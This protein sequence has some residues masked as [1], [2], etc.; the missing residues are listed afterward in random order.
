MATQTPDAHVPSSAAAGS[1][2]AGHASDGGVRARLT[3]AVDLLPFSFGG[4]LICALAVVSGVMVAANPAPR[5][6]GPELWTFARLHHEM[7]EP[8][9]RQWNAGEAD[10]SRHLT[11]LLLS[12][13]AL[14]RRM[15]SGFLSGMPT[16]ELLEVERR[17]AARAFVGPV[18]SVGCVDL[19]E[20]LLA[21]GLL[22]R[23]NAPSFSPW[24][25][26]G[27]IFGIPHDVHPVMLGY[28]ADIVEAAG[29]DVSKIHTWEDFAREMAPL[30]VD[31]DGDGKSDRWLINFWP[32]QSDL[33]EVL[34]LQAGGGYFDEAGV[35]TVNSEANARVLATLVTWC[36]GEP[37]PKG[38]R[39]AGDA[40]DFSASGNALKLE[41]YVV[42]ALMPD[43]MCNIWRNE[44]PQLAGKVKLMPLPAWPKPLPS[45]RRTSVWGGTM[46]GIAR[47]AKDV[48]AMYEVAKRLY[49][50][51]DL[52]RTLYTVG[53]I[54]TPVRDHWSDPIFD[55]PDPFFSGQPKGRMYIDLA[56]DVP[57]RSSSPYYIL[58][59][60]RVQDALLSLKDHAERR[61]PVTVEDLLPEA[62]Q[63]LENAQ[64]AVLVQMRRNTFVDL[65]A[66][67]D[68]PTEPQRGAAQ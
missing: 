64:R 47:T 23:I 9:I 62:R 14:E 34:L 36:V 40:P 1:G 30:M 7:Y 45:Q 15:L 29:I 31:K 51:D 46:L 57:A 21:D 43:W 10:P 65:P 41:G 19:T 52:A 26:R 16:A 6:S 12:M 22:D 44:S 3:R 37:Y 68:A 54:I 4:L 50:S 8:I 33:I 32:S 60:A 55:K 27:R 39:I 17:V 48:D 11:P 2:P 25:S 18:D 20:R 61:L 42:S 63:L 13:P 49:L 53:D 28:R 56:G 59:Q 24:S 58:A 38:K 35:P 5:S 66:G 67:L